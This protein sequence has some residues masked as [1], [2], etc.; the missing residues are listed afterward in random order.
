MP[1]MG[2][3]SNAGDA[4]LNHQP[5]VGAQTGFCSILT[6]DCGLSQFRNYDIS[7]EIMLGYTKQVHIIS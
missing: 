4:C 2:S 5:G 7:S 6:I 3:I 1:F